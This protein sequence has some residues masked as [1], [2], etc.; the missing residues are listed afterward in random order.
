MNGCELGIVLILF[1]SLMMENEIWQTVNRCEHCNHVLIAS[2]V[3]CFPSRIT[4]LY[5]FYY[6]AT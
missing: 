4:I 3:L 5:P 1:G 2:E 6:F